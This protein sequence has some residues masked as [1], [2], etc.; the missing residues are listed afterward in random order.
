MSKN[1]ASVDLIDR[2]ARR[3]PE[4]VAL[5]SRHTAWT[6]R[7]L[8]HAVEA[9]GRRLQD[10]GIGAETRVA[11]HAARTPATIVA[12]WALWRIGAV[13]VP[14]NRRWPVPAALRAAR[15]ART[16][17][18]LA[19]D[20][21]VV[22]A[23]RDAEEE[24]GHRLDAVV[25]QGNEGVVD[26][27]APPPLPPARS[28][29][30]VFTSGTTGA[31]K[32]VLHTWR[33]HV[34]SAAGSNTNIPVSPGDRW[35]L[36]LPLYHVG[37]LAILVR[38]ALGGGT[39]V[40]PSDDASLSDTLADR[41]VTHASL[42][43]TQLRRLL[44][45]DAEHPSSMRALL[46]GGGPVPFDL[47][48]AAHA[49]G[50]PLHTTYGCTEMASQVTTTP[51]GATLDTLLTAGRILPHRRLRIANDG[52]ILVAGA[53]LC[54]GYAD[55]ERLDDP[56]NANGWY[57][58]GDL[59][60]LD[61][62]GRLRVEG[63]KDHMFV[64]GGENVQPEFIEET[65]HAHPDV[66]AAVVVPVADDEFGH[67]P[68]AFVR[69]TGAPV[70]PDALRTHCRS[71]LPAFMVPDHIVPMPDDV[72]ASIKVDRRALQERARRHDGT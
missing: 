35:L 62:Q 24:A 44:E 54:R 2:G 9:T 19:D 1:L 66:A 5:A 36:S 59:G 69:T 13:V 47:L 22:D 61:A 31:P 12:T 11:L 8:H 52:E 37:G 21:G 40:V 55:G 29:T 42:V 65:L 33:N 63:R 4:A 67:R 56:R 57:P 30:I 27:A 7:D 39:V 46:V 16:V 70:S 51:P 68:V 20:D 43:A 3:W 58:T 28:A 23:A 18:W 60:R 26:P 53:T 41:R 32:G 72:T 6:Y 45:A 64:S 25:D 10:V 34:A 71:T 15:G 14:L 48:E 17:T 50:W 38:C 49:R